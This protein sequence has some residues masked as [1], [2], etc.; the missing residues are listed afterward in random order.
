MFK[1]RLGGSA[2]AA[3]WERR[4]RVVQ[5]RTR[6]R[7]AMSSREGEA[8]WRV[9]RRSTAPRA[10]PGGWPVPQKRH[11]CAISC[12]VS[13]VALKFGLEEVGS[14]RGHILL[15]REFQKFP[16]CV[17]DARSG[18]E[19]SRARAGAAASARQTRAVSSVGLRGQQRVCE[20]ACCVGGGLGESASRAARC[21]H[22]PPAAGLPHAAT[23]SRGGFHV[24]W[25]RWPGCA[26]PQRRPC[27][28]QTG[29]MKPP[30][31]TCTALCRVTTYRELRTSACRPVNACS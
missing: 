1:R 29:G 31:Q 23:R 4:Q 28:S 17:F 5:G 8:W 24:L 19:G 21:R 10:R 20:W 25:I 14:C 27:D 15:S 6:G 22:R 11:S 26:L 7:S 18:A 2:H 13:P 30:P 12:N 3:Q 16:S 9:G